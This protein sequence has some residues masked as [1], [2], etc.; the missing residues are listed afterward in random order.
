MSK[1]DACH[2]CTKRESCVERRGQCMDF[3]D[4]RKE[5]DKLIEYGFITENPVGDTDSENG[6]GGDGECQPH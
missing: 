2:W 1:R 6:E 5:R 4:K 3:V